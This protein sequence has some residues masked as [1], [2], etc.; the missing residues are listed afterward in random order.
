[1][2]P[3]ITCAIFS[4][5]LLAC[6]T[7]FG[8][9]II[10]VSN[11]KELRA[12]LRE[13][14]KDGA[15]QPIEILLNDG[16]YH[17]ATQ[18]K[19]TRDNVLIRSASN[20]AKLVTLIGNGMHHSQKNEVIFDVSGS[21][22]TISA[23]TMKNTSH[24]LIQVRAEDNSDYFTLK[25][26]ILKDSY[27]QILKVS[28]RHGGDYS[29]YG[30]I[31]NNHFEYSKGIGPNYYI[32]GI[33]AHRARNW[34]VDNNRFYNIASPADRVAQHAIHFWNGSSDVQVKNNF[35]I[36]S[37]RGIGFGLSVQKAATFGGVISNNYIINTNKNH[38]FSDVGIIL[39]N[40]P[41]TLILKNTI[42]METGYP[43]AIE[44]RFSAS[45]DVVVDSNT[46]NK[47]ITLRDGASAKFQ[48]NKSKSGVF[49]I[50]N[51]FVYQLRTLFERNTG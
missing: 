31:E 10:E 36:D 49:N 18:L 42:Y 5:C 6:T 40:T 17:D 51:N 35:I 39:E 32:G 11:T 27:Q 2:K 29:D 8:S 30:L 16:I 15:K 1:M 25:N 26:S 28:G 24:H 47:S 33:D 19:I 22:V 3:W 12:V 41:S 43:N 23:I 45:T 50:L 14:D 38:P 37:D 48:N 20:D 34:I 7:P 13:L 9:E 44:I 46:T 4:F 21:H